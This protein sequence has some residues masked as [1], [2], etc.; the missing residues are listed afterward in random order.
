VSVS[1][2]FVTHVKDLLAGLGH[3]SAQRMFGG[4]GLYCDGF[5]FAF[6]DEDVLHLKT[7]EPGRAAFKDEGLGPF[8]FTAKDGDVIEAHAYYR[9]PNGCS[10]MRKRCAPGR[11]ERWR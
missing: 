6:L 5:I 10:T 1:D 2:G 4:V 7:D 3:I 8:T 11:R 9:R